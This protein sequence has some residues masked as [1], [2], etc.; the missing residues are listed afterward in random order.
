MSD[1]FFFSD[2][3]TLRGTSFLSCWKESCPIHNGVLSFIF[4]H[5][6][7]TLCYMSNLKTEVVLKFDE[8]IYFL[9]KLLH[10]CVSEVFLP[11]TDCG[12]F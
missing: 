3:G 2:L 5:S 11:F 7:P 1:G 4:A 6:L 10:F 9:R 12:F 8:W